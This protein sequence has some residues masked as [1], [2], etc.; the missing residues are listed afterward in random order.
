MYNLYQNEVFNCKECNTVRPNFVNIYSQANLRCDKNPLMHEGRKAYLKDYLDAKNIAN[1]KVMII[2]Q[3]PGFNGCGFSG[4]P[5]TAEYNAIN[6]L[7]IPNYHRTIGKK[8]T[9]K[10]AENVYEL[11]RQV[12]GQ[13]NISIAELSKQVVMTNAFQCIPANLALTALDTKKTSEMRA[14]AKCC[15]PFLKKQIALVN[16]QCIICLGDDAWHSVAG[17]YNIYD[18]PATF[19][20]SRS[21][22]L[23]TIIGKPFTVKPA[24]A[25]IPLLHPSPLTAGQPTSQASK[26]FFLDI[27]ARYF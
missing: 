19:G 3:S 22:K 12:A 4:I 9:E 10:S 21:T 25:I 24:L 15:R 7:K 26:N 17:L 13:K 11:L 27:I 14:M 6:D 1:V 16:P 8:E 20:V 2:G 18:N 5:F 23:T